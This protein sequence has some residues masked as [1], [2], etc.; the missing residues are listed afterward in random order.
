MVTT[1]GVDIRGRA[2]AHRQFLHRRTR[3]IERRQRTRKNG[4]QRTKKARP[5]SGG[6]FSP[7]DLLPVPFAL[8]RAA[9]VAEASAGFILMPAF[10]LRV[11][12]SPPTP[13]EIFANQ[14]R[15]PEKK[16]KPKALTPKAQ[17]AASLLNKELKKGHIDRQRRYEKFLRAKLVETPKKTYEILKELQAAEFLK[18]TE[19]ENH[20]EWRGQ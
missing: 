12:E 1:S 18:P 4:G 7:L 16:D 15:K 8:S 2:Q 13:E 10:V 5:S 9:P 19:A 17:E 6:R 3:Q 11:E 20:L 14:E